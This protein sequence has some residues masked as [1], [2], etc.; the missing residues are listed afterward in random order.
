[1]PSVFEALAAEQPAAGYVRR[2]FSADLADIDTPPGGWPVVQLPVGWSYT[3]P[4]GGWE[5]WEQLVGDQRYG[6]HRA[7]RW[8]RAHRVLRFPRP[9]LHLVMS[10]MIR[11]TT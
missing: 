7:S 5:V 9:V 4:G 10:V 8:A 3:P 6:A 11:W 2:R 1:M